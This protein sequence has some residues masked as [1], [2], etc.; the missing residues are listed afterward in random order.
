[1]GVIPV[2][3]ALFDFKS[4]GKRFPWG[5]ARK[6]NAWHAIHLEGQDDA[7]PMDGGGFLQAVLDANSDRI[8]F[9]PTQRWGRERAIHRRR[10]ARVAGEVDG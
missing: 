2:R 4:V 1:M 5:D 3:A 10:H 9:A 6:A 7:V 8:A